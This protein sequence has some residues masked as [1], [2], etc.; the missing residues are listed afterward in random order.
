MKASKLKVLIFNLILFFKVS[1]K[2]VLIQRIVVKD[3]LVRVCFILFEGPEMGGEFEDVGMDIEPQ[4]HVETQG[5]KKKFF[6][7]NGFHRVMMFR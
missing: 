5:K 6:F 7:K 2:Y 3:L 4:G 1:V